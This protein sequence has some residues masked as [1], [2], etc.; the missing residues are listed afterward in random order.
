MLKNKRTYRINHSSS[1][2]YH[3]H[4][5]ISEDIIGPH[6]IFIEDLPGLKNIMTS[7]STKK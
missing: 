7:A 4:I 1:L 5:N 6:T 3:F 2:H